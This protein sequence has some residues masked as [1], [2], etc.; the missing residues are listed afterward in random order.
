[1]A[2]RRGC[3]AADRPRQDGRRQAR[4]RRGSGFQPN[5]ADQRPEGDR[6]DRRPDQPIPPRAGPVPHEVEY[7]RKRRM[8]QLV[9]VIGALLILSAFTAAQ[10]GAMDPHARS[11]LLLNLVGSVV[12]T[13]LAWHE[14]Q[15]GFLLLEFVWA[16]V[17]LWG[18]I[19][20][21][22]SGA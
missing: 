6:H 2:G 3:F 4:G 14:R 11:Y 12:L 1:M 19:R 18:L 20:L 13:V 17:S 9:Q 15:W 5:G 8:D 16:A 10:L 7:L 21:R 22:S